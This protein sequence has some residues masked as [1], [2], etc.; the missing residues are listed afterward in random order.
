MMVNTFLGMVHNM[1]N[2]VCSW[3]GLLALQQSSVAKW[4][5]R[6]QRNHLDLDHAWN[7]IVETTREYILA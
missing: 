7:H 2:E 5:G 1:V 3:Y 4:Q 6:L